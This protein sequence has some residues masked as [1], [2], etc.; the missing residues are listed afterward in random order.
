MNPG[1]VQKAVPA[2]GNSVSDVYFNR[3][4]LPIPTCGEKTFFFL[5]AFAPE[6]FVSRDRFGRPVP[7]KPAHSPHSGSQTESDTYYIPSTAIGSILS[8]SGHAIA[9][10]WR[11]P[12]RVCRHRDINFVIYSR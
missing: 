11:S 5:S 4:S 1:K 10:R 12:P 2:S 8:L 7:R 6:K 3:V 9:Y